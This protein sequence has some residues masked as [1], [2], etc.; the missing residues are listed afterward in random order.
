MSLSLFRKLQ[1]E[2]IL[3]FS[4]TVVGRNIIEIGA[5]KSYNNKQFFPYAK[6]YITTNLSNETA[7]LVEDVT[8]L[9]FL[10]D[11]V[12]TIVCISVLQH[13]IEFNNGI[14]EIIRV[15]KPGGRALIT[16]GY[17]FPVCMEHDYF[18]FTPAF[19]ME[20]L[21]NEKV[22]FEVI[23]LG[24][25][26]YAIE[27]LLM[28]PYSKIGGPRGLLNKFLSFIF[29]FLRFLYKKH[30]NAPLGIAVIIEKNS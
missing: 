22:T 20:R 4:V 2:V 17:I 15:L 28:R 18:R 19:W 21:K 16:N 14:D 11:S 10:S 13:V 8:R 3:N 30:D 23:S 26:Y 29:K 12:D 27:N 25:Q 9:T 7:D 6:S 24:N 5:S 1:N